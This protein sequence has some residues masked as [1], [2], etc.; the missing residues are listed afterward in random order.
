MKFYNCRKYFDLFCVEVNFNRSIFK[1]M[2]QLYNF[3]NA[4]YVLKQFIIRYNLQIAI[5]Y[6]LKNLKIHHFEMYEINFNY[7]KIYLQT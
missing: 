4:K 1:Y 7:L 5:S 6:R 3:T 2:Y